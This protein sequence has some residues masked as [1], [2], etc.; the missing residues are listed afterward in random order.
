MRSRVERLGNIKGQDVILLLFTLQPALGQEY[1]GS[2]GGAW[3]GP[4]L[5]I[6]SQPLNCVPGRP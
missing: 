1:R 6:R 5:P 4:K 2:R 3:H